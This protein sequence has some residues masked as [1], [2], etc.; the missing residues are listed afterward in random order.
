MNCYRTDLT[1]LR[2]LRECYFHPSRDEAFPSLKMKRMAHTAMLL[3]WEKDMILLLGKTYGRKQ[4]RH[5]M[6]LRMMPEHLDEAVNF[7]VHF[8]ANCL[9]MAYM[10]IAVWLRRKSG[11]NMIVNL[12]FKILFNKVVYKIASVNR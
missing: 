3:L 9:C 12:I 4:I 10:Q 7:F 2:L 6:I 5:S 11:L 8:Y 1:F